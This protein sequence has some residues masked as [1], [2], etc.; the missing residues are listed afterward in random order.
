MLILTGAMAVAPLI[1][2]A[3][4]K[5][6]MTIEHDCAKFAISDDSKI[7]CAV[8]HVKRMKKIIIQ[9]DDV[10]VASDKGHEKEIVEGEKFVPVPPPASY[11][12]DTLAWSPDGRRIAMSMTTQHPSS[13]DEPAAGAKAIALLDDDGHEIKVEGSKTRFIEGAVRA[14]WLADGKSVVYLTGAGPYKI[15]RVR[16]GDGDTAILFGGATFDAVAWDAKNNQAFALGSNLSLSGRLELVQLDLVHE[17]VREVTRLDMYQGQL[18]ISPSGHKVA[19][20]YDGDTIEVRDLANPT[21]PT[22]VRVGFGQFQWSRD[23]QRVL[24]KRGPEDKSGDLVWVGLYKESFVPALYGLE[25][26]AFQIAPNGEFI[27]V[28]EPGKEVLKVFPLE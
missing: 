25:Y 10:W 5:P 12:V 11:E 18:S 15:S 1:L 17:T 19:F 26:H 21:K 27:A 4:G 23:E 28:T 3:Q 9:R 16:P 8:P 14:T 2:R 24:L 20:F 22:R 7:V 13:E 6:T